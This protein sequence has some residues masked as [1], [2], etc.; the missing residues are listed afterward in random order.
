MKEGLSMSIKEKYAIV[1]VGYTPQG[2][3]TGRTEL[4]FQLEAIINAIDDAGL[5]KEDVDG[6]ICYRNF[7]PASD[8][9][10]VTPYMVAQHLG[11]TPA[12]ISQ[13]AN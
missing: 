4:S 3:I 10:D 12:Y 6:L 5:T 1:G 8:S 9:Y 7:P 13:D 11:I 2:R